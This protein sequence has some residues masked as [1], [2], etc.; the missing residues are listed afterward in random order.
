[1]PKRN[2]TKLI[3]NVGEQVTTSTTI[4][5]LVDAITGLR[6]TIV[7]VK[8]VITVT[9]SGT[10]TGYVGIAL[11]HRRSGSETPSIDLTNGNQLYDKKGDILWH[12]L[13][14]QDSDVDFPIQLPV[15]IKT[16]RV[17]KDG[18]S[19]QL[20][21]EGGSSLMSILATSLTVFVLI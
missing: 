13:F 2:V 15:D 9:P 21:Q 5:G 14:Y 16:R 4:T 20:I 10:N 1:M 17:L 12:R 19:F 8:G 7:G 3:E 6:Q 11:I 18:D